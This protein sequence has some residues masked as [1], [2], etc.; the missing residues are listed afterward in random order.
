LNNSVPYTREE[1]QIKSLG[2]HGDQLRAF[3]NSPVAATSER[4]KGCSKNN[5]EIAK[6]KEIL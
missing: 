3:E 1:I 4:Y 6:R 2:H 5:I